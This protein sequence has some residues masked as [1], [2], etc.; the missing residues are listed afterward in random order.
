[1][2]SLGD[3]RMRAQSGIKGLQTWH[4]GRIGWHMA[5]SCIAW[6]PLYNSIRGELCRYTYGVGWTL[7]IQCHGCYVR[8][9]HF[10]VFFLLSL[11][12]KVVD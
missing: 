2:D 8:C 6:V 7:R 12:D 5:D 11:L 9:R 4:E 10:V 3:D 1:M